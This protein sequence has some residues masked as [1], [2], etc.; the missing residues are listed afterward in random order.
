MKT[1][2]EN[3]YRACLENVS[4]Q[5]L[6]SL[7]QTIHNNQTRPG[8]SLHN[9]ISAELFL[10]AE[11]EIILRTAD[12]E[13]SLHD[14]DMAL[15][16][17]GIPHKNYWIKE[18]SRGIVLNFLCS[19]IKNEHCADLYKML[20]PFM[21]EKNIL[22]YRGQP[23]LVGETIALLA[24]AARPFFTAARAMEQILRL[25]DLKSEA[26]PAAEAY[27][28]QSSRPRD[29]HF[30][31]KLDHLI[32]N[33]YNKKINIREIAEELYISPRQLDR[34]VQ[35]RYGKTLHAVFMDKRIQ[36]AEYYLSSTK[37]SIDKIAI[38]VGFNSSSGLYREFEKKYGITPTAY[39]KQIA[40]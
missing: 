20:A 3:E 11:G 12:Q 27:S 14:G 1:A 15:I 28:R 26:I 10:C 13:I 38:T 37:M 22:L 24:D 19:K 6:I 36:A 17:P 31:M 18:G 9:H 25:L 7:P 29:I 16:P 30:M 34:I 2:Q 39:R 21:S 23:Q 5:L 8:S 32:S 4:F 35:R 33:N 40:K